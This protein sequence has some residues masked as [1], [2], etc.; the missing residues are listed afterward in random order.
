MKVSLDEIRERT[1]KPRDAWWTVLL[2]DPLAA[3]LVRLVAP[4]RKITPNVLTII[5]TVIG[6]GSAACFAMQDRWWLVAGALL[7]H[8]SFIVDCMDGKIARLNGTGSLFGAWFDFVFD[9]IRVFLCALALMGGQYVRTGNDVYLWLLAVVIFL[10]LFRYLNGSQMA[11]VRLDMKEKL[12][13][14]R[15]T[16]EQTAAGETVPVAPTG[17]PPTLKNRVGTWLRSHRIRTHLFSGIEY[18]MTVFI[19]G[20]LLGLVLPVS[21]AAGALLLVFEA[22]LVSKFF[23]QTQR[24]PARLQEAIDQRG[25]DEAQAAEAQAAGTAPIGTTRTEEQVG[26]F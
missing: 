15:G 2:V 6:L 22:W 10:D 16:V 17:P 20:P 5:A 14:A 19:I 4:H 3:R 8:V 25:L 1:Y 18:E 9:R 13:E 11:K 12:D 26:A 7:F 24:F 21:I 23:K